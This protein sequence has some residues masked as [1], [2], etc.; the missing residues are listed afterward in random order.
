MEIVLL[1]QFTK[2]TNKTAQIDK[3]TVTVNNFFGHQFADI[4]IRRYPDDMRILPTNSSADIY[5]Y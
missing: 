5:Q 2:K 1:I 4:D 3:G